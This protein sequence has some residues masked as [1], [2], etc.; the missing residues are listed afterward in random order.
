MKHKIALAVHGG[1]GTIL[2]SKMT[3]ELEKAYLSDRQSARARDIALAQV[4]RSNTRAD[5]LAFLAVAG[6]VLCVYFIAADT[7][8]PERAVNA[9]MFALMSGD[10]Q[11]LD[12]RMRSRAELRIG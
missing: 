5:I 3:A 2:K 6:L 10:V 11:A 9:I 8:L 1:A 4:G 7:N 12:A